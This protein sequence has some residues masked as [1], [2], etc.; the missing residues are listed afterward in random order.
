MGFASKGSLG[1]TQGKGGT[2]TMNLVTTQG[3][4]VGDL[5]VVILSKDT[6]GSNPEV[7][8]VVSVGITNTWTL[9]SGYVSNSSGT[10]VACAIAWSQLTNT[11][12]SGTSIRFTFPVSTTAKAVTG[13]LWSTTD[14]VTEHT[15]STPGENEDSAAA[16]RTSPSAAAPGELLHI[17][18]VAREGTTTTVTSPSHTN[19]TESGVFVGTATS[20]GQTA[21]NAAV[22]GLWAHCNLT[23]GQ[24]NVA[25]WTY[26]ASDGALIGLILKHAGTIARRRVIVSG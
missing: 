6:T 15:W 17:I 22:T 19:A 10:F 21:S 26:V 2:T 25:S 24:Q 18:G 12:P 4:A 1:T 16:T 13:H 9:K 23:S 14:T 5:V 11:I 8:S 7:S 3:A 20:G